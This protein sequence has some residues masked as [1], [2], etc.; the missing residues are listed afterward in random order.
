MAEKPSNAKDDARG[1][2]K[3]RKE[4]KMWKELGR[5]CGWHSRRKKW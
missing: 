1:Y 4:L 5:L 3:K 2:G